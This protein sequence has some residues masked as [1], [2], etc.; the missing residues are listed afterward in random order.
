[1]FP[2]RGGS[3]QTHEEQDKL[4]CD[5]PDQVSEDAI[6]LL[7]QKVLK[8]PAINIPMLPDHIEGRLYETTVR[9]T[10]NAI[11][12]IFRELNG[13]PLLGYQLKL[14]QYPQ[15]VGKTS[16][17]QV[18][19]HASN[20]VN[21]QVLEQAAD[22]LLQ[23]PI[24]NQPLIPDILERQIYINSLKVAFRVLDIVQSSLRI[25]VCGHWLGL[26]LTVDDGDSGTTTATAAEKAVRRATNIL[27][28]TTQEDL[29][30]YQQEAGINNLVERRRGLF[31]W[32][33]RPEPLL[34]QVHSTLFGL[35]FQIVQ[36]ML[37]QTAIEMVG[38]GKIVMDLVPADNGMDNSTITNTKMM[39]PKSASGR[40]Q[41]RR[42]QPFPI[43]IF[44]SGIGVGIILTLLLK[45][46]F[47]ELVVHEVT[48]SLSKSIQTVVSIFNRYRYA[49][50]SRLAGKR[51]K[52]DA[53]NYHDPEDDVDFSNVRI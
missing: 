37:D 12:K 50:F 18:A 27:S 39:V 26:S 48:L 7:V 3:Q 46:R 28:Q 32:F 51:Q 24:I 35:I 41:Q 10:L 47:G 16:A 40:L 6:H 25:R 5:L 30:Q 22:R 52:R 49:F 8:D 42:L 14:Q 29:K 15:T 1:L 23:N 19:S 44:V 38:V 21:Y 4:L 33:L 20:H 9:L 31:S 34:P 45:S 36:D 2:S 17:F 11:F 13:K 43:P 53:D